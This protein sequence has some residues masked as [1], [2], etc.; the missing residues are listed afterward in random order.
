MARLKGEPP[1]AARANRRSLPRTKE[2]IDQCF[3]ADK[4]H[5][6][7]DLPATSPFTGD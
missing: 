6:F 7:L 2:Q 4:D 5:N 3:A 1:V